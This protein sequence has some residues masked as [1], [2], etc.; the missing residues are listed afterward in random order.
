MI[1]AIPSP[2][3][4]IAKAAPIINIGNL[5]TPAISTPT[6]RLIVRRIA[7]VRNRCI[8]LTSFPAF[9]SDSLAKNRKNDESVGTTQRMI[10]A[11]KNKKANKEMFAFKN[12]ILRQR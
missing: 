10:A 7:V 8:I 12:G 5:Y 1:S 11:L 2:N 6:I 3:V 9:K 4:V